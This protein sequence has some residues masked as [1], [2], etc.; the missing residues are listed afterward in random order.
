MARQTKREQDRQ[1]VKE[2][3]ERDLETFIRLV[4][5][6]RVLGSIHSDL[7]AW[8]TREEA[9]PYQLVLLPRDH[10]K[11]ALAAYRVAWEIT[12]NPAI[13]VLYI[14][15]TSKLAQKQLKFIKDILTSSIY[16]YYWPDMVNPEEG[17]REKWTESEIAVDHP[18]RKKEIIRDP[19]VFTAGLTTSITGLHCDVAV[20]DDV[21]V[22]ENAYTEDG[23]DRTKQQYSLLSSIEGAEAREWVVG[24]RY[25]PKD[26]YNDLLEMQEEIFDEHGDI[27][28]TEALYEKFEARVEDRG[29]GT[30]EFLWPRQQRYDGKWFGFN[31]EI[32]AK[33][34][35]QYLDK[36]QFRA[37]YYNDPNSYEDAVID[38]SDF[39]YFDPK[40]ITRKDGRWYFKDN[41]INVFAAVD[42]AYSL[43]KRADYTCIVV[44]GVDANYNYYVLDIDRFKT[45]KISDYFECIL[46]LFTKWDFRK[47]RAEVTAAQSVIV[48]DLKRN[49]IP[50]YGLALSIDEYRP[51]RELGSKEER[52]EAI[53]QPRYSNKQMWHYRGGNCQVLEEELI[54]AN[55][56]HD[57]VKDALAACV[58]VCVAP[59]SGSFSRKHHSLPFHPRFGGVI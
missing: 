18:L 40:H 37:Q 1:L 47:L 46:S 48:Q 11:S 14:S 31:K 6:Q 29:D 21:V 50:R 15:S 19:T 13:R 49:Y 22:K 42:F 43:Q 45:D 36:I 58:D 5:P 25:Y 3:A 23:R 51:S 10:Q 24:T 44:V 54:L 26:L 59:T 30:G 52:I 56:P 17:K 2:A 35:A 32:L 34:R 28:D 33:K 27:V 57:D 41:R 20:L 55:P 38:R 16:T 9:K 12:K 53:L 7:I 8:W 4:H 39:Q